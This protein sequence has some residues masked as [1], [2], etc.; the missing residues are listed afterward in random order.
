MLA[1]MCTISWKTTEETAFADSIIS[2]MKRSVQ[3]K[4]VKSA[5]QDMSDG[6]LGDTLK[7]WNDDYFSKVGLFVHLE[8]SESAMKNPNQKSKA[9]R[10]P[11]MFYSKGEERDKKKDERKY[12]IVVTKLDEDGQPT[13][14]IQELNGSE[15][16]P[17]EIGSSGDPSM[18]VSELPGDEGHAAVE[19][20]AD[21]GRTPV[22]L[23]AEDSKVDEKKMETPEIYV[24]KDSDNTLLLEK[25][26][27]EN[28]GVGRP[29]LPEKD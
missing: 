21:E 2:S 24:E 15:V 14:A 25:L 10:K 16:T 7:Q 28:T 9:F 12:V 3:E 11:G 18:S 19:L 5:L 22:E 27:L 13:E 29:N 20:P 17:V 4:K 8:L 6:G 23:P 26:Q 1:S